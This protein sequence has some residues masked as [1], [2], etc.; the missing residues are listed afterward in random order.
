MVTICTYKAHTLAS[1][2][3]IDMLMQAKRIKYDVIGLVETRRGQPFNA[4]YDTR[5]EL[6]FEHAIVQE[7]AA[8][9]FSSTRVCP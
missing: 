8:S 7:S 3:S 9:A 6:F 5:E 1:E 2:S 4:V